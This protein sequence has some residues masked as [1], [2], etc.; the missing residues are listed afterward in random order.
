[1]E[2]SDRASLIWKIFNMEER[3]IKAEA[4]RDTARSAPGDAASAVRLCLSL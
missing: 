4:E 1:M 3:G 2:N